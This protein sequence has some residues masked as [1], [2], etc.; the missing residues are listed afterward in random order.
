VTVTPISQS[1]LPVG[2]T[3]AGPFDIPPGTTGFSVTI[4]RTVPGGLNELDATT[5][6]EMSIQSSPDGVTWNDEGGGLTT[7]GG[8]FTDHHGQVDA[9][10]VSVGGMNPGAT[11]VGAVITVSGPVQ[12]VIAG[13]V[14]TV[15]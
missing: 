15:P 6:F 11:V 14:T 10:A 1:T 5:T 13:S 8:I 2:T 7:T 4:D 12:V 3:F 9:N